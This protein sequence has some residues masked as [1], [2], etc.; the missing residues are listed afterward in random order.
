MD[1][2]INTL[3]SLAYI[4]VEPSLLIMLIILSVIFY[5]KNK[6]IVAMQRMIIGEAINSPIELT[7]AQIVFGLL[8]GIIGSIMLSSVGVI[9]TEN[10]GII[11]LFMISIVLMFIKPRFI[12][13]SYSGAILGIV[14]IIYYYLAEPLGLDS[15]AFNIDITTLMTFVG[16]LHIVEAML[17]AVD[18]EKGAI[19]VF[20]NRNN[21]IIGGY[22]LSRYWV[23]PISIFIAYKLGIDNRGLTETIITPDWWPILKSEN[24]LAILATMAIY[25]SPFFG[26]IGYSSVSFTK[27]KKKKVIASSMFIFTFGV[28]LILVAQVARFGVVGE[29]ITVIFAPVGHEIML[30]MQ[31]RSEDRGVPVFYSGDDGIAVLEVVPYSEI[32]DLGI[33]SG[34]K[35]V[36]LNG[37]NVTSEKEIYQVAKDS[38]NSFVIKAIS[39]S[40]KIK[41]VTIK[42]G[43]SKGIGVLLVP[44]VVESDKVVPIDQ[45]RFSDVL[46]KINKKMN[47]NDR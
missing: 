45:N 1:L 5:F 27:T 40:G 7:L 9:F 18:G 31:R 21:R 42:G 15:S 3:S 25:I 19:P 14:S 29:I 10:S 24:V 34:D 38:S 43:K 33:R 37:N 26:V 11:Y 36:S 4:I 30:R 17:V 6:K 28:I 23:L 13:F 46:H 16:C 32:Y 41:E 20:S 2:L 12:C 8:A 39:I 44:R 35:I 22:A 47:N